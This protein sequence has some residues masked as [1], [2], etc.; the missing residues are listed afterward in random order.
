MAGGEDGDRADPCGLGAAGGG[1]DQGAVILGCGHGGGQGA[2]HLNQAA[3]ER[4][5]ADR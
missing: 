5:L 1:A 2:G 4:Q 3:V